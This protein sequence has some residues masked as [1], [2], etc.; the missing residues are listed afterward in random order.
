M[1]F[2]D[3]KSF[4]IPSVYK[5]RKIIGGFLLAL[6]LLLAI[7]PIVPTFFDD[8]INLFVAL[9]INAF[10]GLDL[11]SSLII[12]YTIFPFIVFLIGIVVYPG[13]DDKDVETFVK[14]LRSTTKQALKWLAKPSHLLLVIV[15]YIIIF[16]I[17]SKYVP[18]DLLY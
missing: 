3:F 11:L 1:Q 18:I 9:Q 15:V 10:F 17:Y 8:L 16:Y 14:K 6:A 12:S 13:R 2:P 5:A 4:K 7:P